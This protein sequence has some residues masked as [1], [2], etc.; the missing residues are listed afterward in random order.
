MNLVRIVPLVEGDGEVQ[1]V[2]VLLRRIC[3]AINPAIGVEVRQGFRHPSGKLI[4]AGGLERAVEAVATKH[5]G[6]HI[7]ILIDSDDDCPKEFGPA[8]Q[9]RATKARPDINISVVLAHREYEAW[10]LAAAESLLEVPP[11]SN[12]EAIRDAKGWL[13]QHLPER[14]TYSPTQD[15]AAWSQRFDM[16]AAREQSRSFQK[17]WSE[18]ERI[19][20]AATSRR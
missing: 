13:T 18:V 8:L 15:Q 11:P 14:S 4:R 1:A 9:A 19:L 16:G 10:F 20:N 3:A 2:P 7:L 17:L 12:P 6:H 5:P